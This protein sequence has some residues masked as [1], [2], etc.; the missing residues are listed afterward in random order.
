ME[1]ME[2]NKCIHIHRVGTITLGIGLV[3]MGCLFLTHMFLPN[4]SYGFIYRV[5]PALLIMLGVEV[6]LSNANRK[7]EF[8]YDKA[9]MFLVGALILFSMFMA[10]ASIILEEFHVYKTF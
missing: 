5:W 1:K 3:G 6:L 8:V 2:I 4:L 7:R 9:A 10:T